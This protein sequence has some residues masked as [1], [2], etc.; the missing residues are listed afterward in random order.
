MLIECRKEL[1]ALVRLQHE[2]SASNASTVLEF[3]GGFFV[4]IS[5]ML[6]FH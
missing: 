4:I 3:L 5:S 2:L 1:L 6:T